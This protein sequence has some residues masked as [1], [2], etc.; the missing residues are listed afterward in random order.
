MDKPSIKSNFFF[1]ATIV[2]LRI[3]FP[4]IVFPFVSR[5]LMPEG[6][7]RVNYAQAVVSYFVLFSALGIPLYGIRAIAGIAASKSDRQKIFSEIFV[8]NALLAILSFS[9]LAIAIHFNWITNEVPLILLHSLLIIF[10]LFEAEWYYQGTEN[11]R[12]ITFR[13]IIVKLL[14]IV[15]IF[16]LVKEVDDYWTYAVILVFGLGGNAIFNFFGILREFGMSLIKSLFSSFRLSTLKKHLGAIL[17]TSA[18]SLA[19]SIYLN[20]DT[21][22][23]GYFSTQNEVGYYTAAMR[24]VR[25]I[26]S[27]VL[28]LNTV[29]L[30]RASSLAESKDLDGAKIILGL[31][32]RFIVGFSIPVILI[33]SFYASPIIHLFAGDTF[34]ASVGLLEL[35]GLLIFFVSMSNMMGLQI[36]YANKKEKQFLVAI[37]LGAALNLMLNAYWIPELQ[38]YGAA[39]SSVLAE[40]LI[41][42]LLLWY[43][44]S[45]FDKQQLRN[46]INYIISGLL[47]LGFIMAFKYMDFSLHSYAFIVEL[48]FAISAYAIALIFMKDS[49]F[50]R[51]IKKGSKN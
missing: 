25:A 17:L 40:G 5:I 50:L 8:L 24:I 16:V 45:Y 31:N 30:P 10:T 32:L 33:F 49:L 4:L 6:I 29:L 34:M 14:S 3:A 1:N 26:I 15:A 22:M 9:I 13:N 35:L 42:M 44:S 28:A 12:F 7:G 37:I 20:L 48:V 27:V 36:L 23:I 47:M 21:V 46:L 51:L 18:L 2:V 41:F 39:L 43:T 11:Y 38:A 19:G